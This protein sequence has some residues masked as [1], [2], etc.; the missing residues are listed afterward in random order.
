VENAFGDESI[1]GL[2]APVRVPVAVD[3][4]RLRQS[5]RRR[6]GTEAKRSRHVPEKERKKVG[7]ENDEGVDDRVGEWVMSVG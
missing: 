2:A 4:T 6:D 5:R 7:Q 3:S 1:L